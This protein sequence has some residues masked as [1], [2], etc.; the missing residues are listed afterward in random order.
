MIAEV[1]VPATK[2]SFISTS[3]VIK[4][5]LLPHNYPIHLLTKKI[6]I[7]GDFWAVIELFAIQRDI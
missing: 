6:Y 3:S 5:Y 2:I 4:Q 1:Q 7:L